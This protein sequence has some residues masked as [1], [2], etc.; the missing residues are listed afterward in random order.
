MSSSN[1]SQSC[2][3][4]VR[5]SLRVARPSLIAYPRIES[6]EYSTIFHR[7][8]EN[9]GINDFFCDKCT[10]PLNSKCE[11]CIHP[12]LSTWNGSRKNWKQFKIWIHAE[13][14]FVVERRTC[15]VRRQQLQEDF[16]L[17]N[18]KDAV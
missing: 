1:K 3:A 14:R 5:D 15:I 18:T 4:E 17:A 12:Y 6:L 13:K 7:S 16:L 10:P 11:N 9:K 8:K 2:N